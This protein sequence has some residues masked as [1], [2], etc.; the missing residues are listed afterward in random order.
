MEQMKNNSRKGDVGM[1]WKIVTLEEICEINMGK[2]PSRSN[3]TYW[4]GNMP[5]VSIADL[6]G[7]TYITKTKECITKKAILESGIKVVHKNTL[8]YSF[9]LS[10]GKVAITGVDIFTNEAIVALPI[11]NNDIIDLKYL[12]WA[13]QNIKLEGIGD[14]AVM[15]LTLNK[16]KLK[17]LE[18]PLPPLP[19]QKRI[20]EILDA[21]DALRR[22]DQALLKKYDELAQAIFIDMFGDPV[23]NEKGWEMK[24]VIDYC[25]CIVPGRD[26]PKTFSGSTPWVT[27]D[28][29][30]HL[31]VTVGSKKSIGLSLFEI[32][33]VKAKV[34][35]AQSV[36]MTCVGDLGVVS[37]NNSDIVVNQ[38]LHA[39][40]CGVKMNPFF[41]MYNL[42]Y[43]KDFMCKMASSTTVPYMNKTIC[44]S[45]PVI[46]PPKELQD[47]FAM[48]ID[49][50]KILKNL[51]EKNHSEQLFDSLLE[52]AFK[53]ELVK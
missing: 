9:K 31:S 20:A 37:V 51:F 48:K 12:Y 40:Q 13:I 18:I 21:A 2:T 6:K 50:I 4:N 30:K 36:I 15:G 3:S 26:K 52:Q 8:L 16:E 42:S 39:F 44:N 17:C 34:I 49:N 27:T 32:K 5:W 41:L 35:P 38:Q 43:Q 7:D 1:N 47:S 23:K 29:L 53:G 45:I 33:E 25:D 28:D 14:K 22:K 24:T 46:C 10:I 11:K 19:I